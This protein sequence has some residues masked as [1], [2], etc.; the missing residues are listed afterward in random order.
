MMLSLLFDANSSKAMKPHE[1][2]TNHS[3][4]I[5]IFIFLFLGHWHLIS[6]KTS[7]YPLPQL[8]FTSLSFSFIFV[9][10]KKREIYSLQLSFFIYVLCIN[11]TQNFNLL[12]KFKYKWICA[13]SLPDLVCGQFFFSPNLWSIL[14]DYIG[15]A[16]NCK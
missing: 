6:F 10:F 15:Y 3:I 1:S 4:F 8:F 9:L 12:V 13:F 16:C 14:F 11:L 2:K 5:Y 7:F